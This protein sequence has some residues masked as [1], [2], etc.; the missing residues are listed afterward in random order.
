MSSNRW[1]ELTE[2]NPEHSAWYVERFRAMA[3]AGDD[4]AGEALAVNLPGT[5]RE[6]PNWRRRMA[7]VWTDVMVCSFA[8]LYGR[9]ACGPKNERHGRRKGRACAPSQ[10]ARQVRQRSQPAS[11]VA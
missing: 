2:Q 1:I 5:D 7:T 10:P 11:S 4:L 3:A 6:R 8:S 9:Q